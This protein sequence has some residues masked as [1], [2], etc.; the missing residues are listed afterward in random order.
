MGLS[1]MAKG[2]LSKGAKGAGEAASG[3][4]S[5]SQSAP[6]KSL[7]GNADSAMHSNIGEGASN[8]G[9]EGD[10]FDA[11]SQDKDLGDKLQ[12][13]ARDKA[14]EKVADKASDKLSGKGNGQSGQGGLGGDNGLLSQATGSNS[15]AGNAASGASNAASGAANAA[16]N[17]G[18]MATSATASAAG[19]A[20]SVGSTIGSAISSAAH[21]IGSALAGAATSVT[22]AVGA[23]IAGVS[24][25]MGV[26]TTTVTLGAAGVVAAGAIVVGTTATAV[27]NN[28]AAY[29]TLITDE[30]CSTNV[31]AAKAAAE[32]DV[33]ADAKMLKNAQTLYSV[34]K[35]RGWSDN[36]IAGMLSN[37]QAEGSIDPTAIEGISGE[38]YYIGEE[39]T[40]AINDGFKS[41]T[42]YLLSYYHAHAAENGWDV[43]D[44]SYIV[45]GEYCPGL[46]LCQWTGGTSKRL[47]DCAASVGVDWYE[48]EFQVAYII[49][50]DSPTGWSNWEEK[51]KSESGDAG[52]EECARY[53]ALLY[54]NGE[55]P[56][57]QIKT[58]VAGAASWAAQMKSWSVD[59]ATANSIIAMAEKMGA[60]SS[61]ST[62]AS[63]L[64]KC[65]KASNADN[66]TLASAAVSFAWEH[67]NPDA[68][69]NDGTQ[70]YQAVFEA[71]L[72][73]GY[74]RACDHVV[75]AAVRWSGTDIDYPAGNCLVQ[76]E[77]C[78]TSDK[79]ERVGTLGVDI[80]YD[81]LQPGDVAICAG[82]DAYGGGS[83]HTFLYVGNDAVKAK[84]P[85]SDY[86]S[87]N[88]SYDETSYA[89]SRS[90]GCSDDSWAINDSRGHYAIFRCVKPDNSDQYKDAGAGKSGTS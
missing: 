22:S 12:D 80:Q 62:V 41:L 33:D 18:N 24:A 76:W 67:A 37:F 3:S 78:T 15:G 28:P 14:A 39:K 75:A 65:Q 43:R 87:V 85:D 9:R 63:A 73:D 42:E 17:I 47:R 7:T 71:T 90:A 46:G 36:M 56:E 25:A 20:T 60:A 72:N 5:G 52:A 27:L 54:E 84:Y 64:K 82:S 1:D 86:T 83:K 23:G 79:W 6:H 31:A 26:A 59:S 53:F 57:G 44:S 88:G 45:D 11:G 21:A 68:V 2:A 8:A 77:Y 81:D 40:K 58:H 4:Q 13:K 74:H 30:D 69:G 89:K 49:A 38:R 48:M 55:M 50:T 19:A 10:A 32:G 35:T 29:D 51:Y 61:S 70:L 66:S 34:F 16:A